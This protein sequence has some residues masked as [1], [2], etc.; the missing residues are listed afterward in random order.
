MHHRRSQGD[1]KS[2]SSITSISSSMPTTTT[3]TTANPSTTGRVSIYSMRERVIL[4]KMTRMMGKLAP[5]TETEVTSRLHQEIPAIR[6]DGHLVYCLYITLQNLIHLNAVYILLYH[7]IFWFDSS[8]SHLEIMKSSRILEQT[9]YEQTH[10]LTLSTEYYSI[11]KQ[12]INTNLINK[13]IYFSLMGINSI[14]LFNVF[15]WTLRKKLPYLIQRNQK[16][17]YRLNKLFIGMIIFIYFIFSLWLLIHTFLTQQLP[18]KCFLLISG[19]LI[20]L[21]LLDKPNLF[22]QSPCNSIPRKQYRNS[23]SSSSTSSIATTTLNRLSYRSSTST[24]PRKINPITNPITIISWSRWS[25]IM[26]EKLDIHECSTFY[27]QAR[28]EANNLWPSVI[29]RIILTIYR[30]FASFILLNLI[31]IKTMSKKKFY[32]NFFENIIYF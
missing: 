19:H 25:S 8:K 27:E 23:T 20:F 18:F 15:L 24:Q 30:T 14:E 21:T 2:T 17:K 16:L 32:R 28:Q 26:E 4:N 12:S 13:Y 29:R 22:R 31:P 9:Q 7:A 3:T 6:L 5:D 11:L 10:F 1:S